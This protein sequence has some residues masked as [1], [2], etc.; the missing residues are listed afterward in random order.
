MPMPKSQSPYPE[1]PDN[2]PLGDYLSF[3]A[4]YDQA[5]FFQEALFMQYPED[6]H[7]FPEFFTLPSIL[8]EQSELLFTERLYNR[9]VKFIRWGREV[10]KYP[11]LR[12]RPVVDPT[13]LSKVELAWIP[14]LK[15]LMSGNDDSLLRPAQR[16]FYR[17]WLSELYSF[18]AESRIITARLNEIKK[19]LDIVTAES[20]SKLYTLWNS[21]MEV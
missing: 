5:I 3:V 2:L 19:E 16:N 21:C 7:H 8:A 9:M 18:E 14:K 10:S 12:G 15:T 13:G 17:L 1:H 4:L 11:K 20:Y 6:G